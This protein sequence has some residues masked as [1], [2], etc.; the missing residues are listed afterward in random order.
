MD[1][2]RIGA[3]TDVHVG[4]RKDSHRLTFGRFLGLAALFVPV[5]LPVQVAVA[6][7]CPD[8]G[9]VFRARHL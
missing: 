7:P 5:T 3:A 4:S 1:R 6:E 9:V 8:I 2:V